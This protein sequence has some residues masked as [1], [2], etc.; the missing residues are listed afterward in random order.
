MSLSWA[1]LETLARVLATGLQ[2]N[3]IRDEPGVYCWYRDG[4]PVYVDVARYSLRRRLCR[5]EGRPSTG[6]ARCGPSAFRPSIVGL[7]ARQGALPEGSEDLAAAVQGWVDECSVTWVACGRDDAY[8]A[9]GELLEARRPL[10][11]RWW[12]RPGEDRLLLRYLEQVGP[13]YGRVYVEVPVGGRSFGNAQTRF[14][15][16]MRFPGLEP[17]EVRPY[18]QAAFTRDGQQHPFELIEVKGRLN[19][20]VIGQLLAAQDLVRGQW[21]VPDARLVAVCAIDDDAMRYVCERRGIDVHIVGE[22]SR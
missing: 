14:V 13:E 8:A 3:A 19:R 17:A 16:A 21:D 10:L 5:I 6:Q 1:D 11:N 12:P 22:A 9:V 4:E 7:L 15:D 18:E 20:P 2:A